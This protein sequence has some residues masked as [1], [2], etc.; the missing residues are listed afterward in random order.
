MH[1]IELA[2][3]DP[4]AGTHRVQLRGER[5]TRGAG[6]DDQNARPVVEISYVT[7]GRETIRARARTRFGVRVTTDAARFSWRF[8]GRTGEAKPGLLVL[9]APTAGRYTLYVDVNGHGAKA[10]VIVTPR[11]RP[12]RAAR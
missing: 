6:T 10:R 1:A 3:D 8:A 5:E 4:D 12:S 9:R 11:P 2:I 7:L